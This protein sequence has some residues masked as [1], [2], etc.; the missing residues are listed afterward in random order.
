M[1]PNTHNAK[2]SNDELRMQLQIQ[3]D[4]LREQADKRMHQEVEY[5]VNEQMNK[6]IETPY[7]Q[8][9]IDQKVDEYSKNVVED[10]VEENNKLQIQLEQMMAQIELQRGQIFRKDDAIERYK[11]IIANMNMER[12]N[13]VIR[14]R[15]HLC[16]DSGGTKQNG[17]PCTRVTI[18]GRCLYHI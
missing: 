6:Y 18:I 15:K 8:E 3:A 5:R 11:R 4:Q 17:A 1:L 10:I 7:V 2:I 13:I 12:T 14:N 9:F 16:G